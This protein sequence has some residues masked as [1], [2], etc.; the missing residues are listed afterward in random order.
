[1]EILWNHRERAE[2]KT[3]KLKLVDVPE[4]FFFQELAT[5]CFKEV[6]TSAQEGNCCYTALDLTH[7]FFA[8][9]T[10]K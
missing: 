5:H 10:V 7:L 2:K 6:T 4:L 3:Q 1:M 9:S 8:S